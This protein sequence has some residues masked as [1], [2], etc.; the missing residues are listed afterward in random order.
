ML[1]VPVPSKL[2]IRR[3]VEP[4]EAITAAEAL[5]RFN[6]VQARKARVSVPIV[7]RPRVAAVMYDTAFGPRTPAKFRAA[8]EAIELPEEYGPSTASYLKWLSRGRASTPE[9]IRHTAI[10]CGLTS[11]D[12]LGDGRRRHVTF[13][14][15]IAIYLCHKITRRSAAEL[16]R[17]FWGKDHSSIL[18]AVDRIEKLVTAN[19]PNT[20]AHLDAIKERLGVSA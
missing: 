20:L 10:H 17:A 7:T 3:A 2:H 19:D 15:H 4:G 1:N 14:R 9:I 11:E 8:S 16:G 6:S 12:I 5:A 13:A 18:H